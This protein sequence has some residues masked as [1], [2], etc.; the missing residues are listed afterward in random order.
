MLL[1]F[2]DS[3]KQ[4]LSWLSQ[5]DTDIL[6]EFC[7]MSVESMSKGANQ[8]A[9]QTAAQKLGVQPETVRNAIDALIHLL[10]MSA[11][12]SIGRL[13]FTDSVLSL[14]FSEEASTELFK[15][16]EQ[17][18]RDMR[19]LLGSLSLELPHYH[20]L[21]WR[22]DVQLASRSLYN[23]IEPVLLLQLQC[24]QYGKK[25]GLTLQTDPTTLVHLTSV[26]EGAL[27]EMK[28]PHCRRIIRHLK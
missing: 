16:Y 20:D 7:R 5:L 12:L 18:Q 1:V 24:M 8:R 13:D 28:T 22:A 21:H 14:G 19:R 23:Q 11:K 17:Q 27:N 9:C 25:T 3:H 15:V 4:H 26:L 2:E 10:T 6:R